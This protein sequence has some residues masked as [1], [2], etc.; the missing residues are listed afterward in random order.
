MRAK[1]RGR[2]LTRARVAPPPGVDL[3]ALAARAVYQ[4]SAEHK[5]H[6]TPGAGVRRLRSDASPCPADVSRDAAESWLRSALA[7]GDVG[8]P[9]DDQP[10]P[11]YAWKRVNDVVFEARLTNAEQ[12]WYKGW[13]LDRTEWPTWLT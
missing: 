2:P 10:Y 1:R 3:D 4:P 12:G 13:P 6:Y 9:W 8:A 7:A 11:Q 5:D